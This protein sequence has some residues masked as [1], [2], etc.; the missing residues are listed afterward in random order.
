ML[1][2]ILD[3][4]SFFYSVTNEKKKLLSAVKYELDSDPVNE[5]KQIILDE[6]LDEYSFARTNVFSKRPFF[7]FVPVAEYSYDQES[8]FLKNAYESRGGETALNIVEKERIHILHEYEKGFA[9]AIR[10]INNSDAIQHI[11]IAWMK[12]AQRNGVYVYYEDSK[13]SIYVRADERFQYFN[14]FNLNSIEDA[15]YFIMLS[16]NQLKLSELSFPLYLS[17]FSSDLD[18]LMQMIRN[19][20]ANVSFWNVGFENIDDNRNIVDLYIA[21]QC[22]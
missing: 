7:T 6:K 19:Y 20:I 3:S 21:A 1:S 10:D 16:Y 14:L 8:S 13:L 2:V 22:E 15:L 5:I 17:G 9:E 18:Q 12:N 4:D 11:S